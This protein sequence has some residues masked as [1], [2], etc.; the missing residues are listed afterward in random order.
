ML[1]DITTV[2]RIIIHSCWSLMKIKIN[3]KLFQDENKKSRFHGEKK[4]MCFSF[5]IRDDVDKT[6]L[7]SF[8]PCPRKL[9]IDHVLLLMAIFESSTTVHRWTRT[10]ITLDV[11]GRATQI[12]YDFDFLFL[13]RLHRTDSAVIQIK[14]FANPTCSSYDYGRSLLKFSSLLSELFSLVKRWKRNL[15]DH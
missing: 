2:Q 1:Q 6:W 15:I 9:L 7:T 14:A 8:F 5:R 11:S 3:W 4:Q 10:P 13:V 12:R